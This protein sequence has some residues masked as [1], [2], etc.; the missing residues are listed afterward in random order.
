MSRQ[1]ELIVVLDVDTEAE[2]LSIVHEAH[3]CTWFKIGS[4]LFTR[5]GPSIVNKLHAAGK[6]VMLPLAEGFTDQQL[7]DIAAYLRTIE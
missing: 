3:N 4:Q 1:T 6:S 2:A 7:A 5:C